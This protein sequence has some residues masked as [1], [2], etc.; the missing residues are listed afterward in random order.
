M[1]EGLPNSQL[2]IWGSSE[3]ALVEAGIGR[4]VG[5]ITHLVIEDTSAQISG[6]RTCQHVELAEVDATMADLAK[7]KQ[8]AIKNYLILGQ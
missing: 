4:E 2:R 6:F 1:R 3:R 5:H 8:W 7:A